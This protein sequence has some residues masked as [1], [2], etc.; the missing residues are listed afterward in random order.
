MTLL[1]H[2]TIEP[3]DAATSPFWSLTL[4]RWATVSPKQAHRTLE[5]EAPS[6]TCARCGTVVNGLSAASHHIELHQVQEQHSQ[7]EAG[8]GS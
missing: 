3:K 8:S 2:P 7:H 4:P 6:W 5:S 1:H